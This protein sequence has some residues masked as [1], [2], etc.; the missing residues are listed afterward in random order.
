MVFH[1]LL[2]PHR[3]TESVEIVKGLGVN[4]IVAIF[5]IEA[6][7]DFCRSVEM[8]PEPNWICFALFLPSLP[9]PFFFSFLPL[10][11]ACSGAAVLATQL[12]IFTVTLRN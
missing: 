10:R 6:V 2:I 9:S 8:M 4:K 3:G 12:R 7:E 1:E 5:K 11:S